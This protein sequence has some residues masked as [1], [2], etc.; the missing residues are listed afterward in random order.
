MHVIWNACGYFGLM[1]SKHDFL[2]IL[3]VISNLRRLDNFLCWGEGR[4]TFQCKK[5]LFFN[6]LPQF[7]FFFYPF[8]IYLVGVLDS[9]SYHNNLQQTGGSKITE[10]YS[11]IVREARGL[12]SSCQQGHASFVFFSTLVFIQGLE[13]IF[14]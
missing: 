4:N 9:Y 7:Y 2:R 8:N 6:N 13:I 5:I 12:K 10:I 11:L 1:V 3:S 14:S